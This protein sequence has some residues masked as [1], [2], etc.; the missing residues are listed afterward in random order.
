MTLYRPPGT[1]IWTYRFFFKGQRFQGSTGETD[2]RKAERIER[3]AKIEVQKQALATPHQQAGAGMTVLHAVS[4]YLERQRS[5]GNINLR[6]LGTEE[7]EFERIVDWI[8]PD[9][10]MSNVTLETMRMIVERRKL[11]PRLNGKGEPVLKWNPETRSMEP[12]KLSG[13]TINRYTWSLFRRVYMMA[14]DE[15][16]VPVTPIKWSLLAQREAGP[17]TREIKLEEEAKIREHCREDYG[18]CFMFALLAGLRLSN[19]AT[20]TWQQIDLGNREIKVVQKGGREH[21]IKIDDEM[22]EILLNERGKHP[23]YVFTFV[24]RK[25]WT[26][27]KNGLRY[28]A[29]KRYPLTKWG[30][31]TWFHRTRT[32]LGF[33]IRI[34]DCRR[35]SGGRLLRGTGNL[36]AV[37]Q[38]L[39]HANIAITAKHYSHV[40]PAD[41]LELQNRANEAS[42]RRR[43]KLEEL[44]A[45]SNLEADAPNVQVPVQVSPTRKDKLLKQIAKLSQRKTMARRRS[46]PE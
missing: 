28:V 18:A 5:N 38:H 15:W 9:T 26:N 8:G 11:Q 4:K 39:G 14:R 41:M 25:T 44:V 43:E 42:K 35:T 34:H 17:R 32:K 46:K 24:C 10:L 33:D 20:L 23:V 27:P 30:F 1:N 12:V 21:V 31:A 3:A 22:L 40:P 13:A 7:K 6:D 37:Q 45:K 36:R 29:G 19:F 2:K 16:Q